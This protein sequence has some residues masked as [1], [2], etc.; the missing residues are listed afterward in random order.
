[1]SLIKYYNMH[2]REYLYSSWL[3]LLII[4]DTLSCYEIIE[5][6]QTG[7]MKIKVRLKDH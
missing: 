3:P 2:D 1:M 5:L 7:Q 4:G 6:F